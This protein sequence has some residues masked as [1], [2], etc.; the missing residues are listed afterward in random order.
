M[1]ASVERPKKPFWTLPYFPYVLAGASVAVVLA[2]T[3][4]V[5]PAKVKWFL[6]G[7]PPFI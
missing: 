1:S 2:L 3:I 6:C 7:N 5:G 4:L